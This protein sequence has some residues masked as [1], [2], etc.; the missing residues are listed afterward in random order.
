LLTSPRPF[1]SLARR[2]LVVAVT[3]AL[4][5][6]FGSGPALAAEIPTPSEFLGIPVGAD[7]TIAD[8]RQIRGYFDALDQAS[9]RVEVE[10]LGETTLGEE[11]FL[12][13]ISSEA[14]VA[15]KARL[16]QISRQIAD[17][18]GLSDPEVEALVAEG[19]LILL[20]T[21]NIHSTE[22]GASQMAMEWAHA[23]ASA[24][25]EETVRRLDE[26]MLLLVPS[27]NPDGQVM[28]TEWYRKNLDTDYEG[29]PMP[30]LYH[31]YA[32]HD[33]NRDWFMLTQKETKAV[34]RAVYH[35]WLPQVWL[36]E[37]QMGRDGPRMFLPPYT[38][39]V[40]PDIHPLV[41]REVNLIGAQMALRLEQAGKSGVIYGY[42][43]DAYW[44]G[45]TK[46]TAWWKNVSGLLTEVASVRYATPV[47]V[48]PNELS[49]G[50]KGLVEYGP[51]TSF[52]NPWPGG[53]WR[54]RDIMDYERIASDAILE[55][56]ADRREDFLRNA[57]VRARAAVAAFGERDAYR[58]PADQR[59][60]ATAARLAALMDEHG[61]EVRRAG[62]GDVYIPLAQ[63]Y[64]LFVREMLSVQRYPQVKLVSGQDIVRPYDVSAWTL[65]LMMGVEAERAEMPVGLVA[66]TPRAVD[67][68]VG[69][70]AFAIA[71]GRPEAARLVNAALRTNG[72]VRVARRALSDGV[73]GWPAGTVF[74]DAAAARAAAEK[75]VPAQSWVPVE[76]ILEAAEPLAAPR[77]G[78]YKP[79]QASMDE[80]W[81]RFV[82]E[83]YGFEPKTLDN[84]AVRQGDL[85]ASFDVIVLP[86]VPKETIETGKRRSRR[87]GA[88]RYAPQLP[89]EYR[90]GLEK[91]GAEALRGFVEG[92]GTLV[93]LAESSEY[94]MEAF[95]LPVRNAL[96]NGGEDFACPGALLRAEVTPDHP[97]TWGL[98]GELAVFQ[99]DE[100]AFDT[101]LPGAEM[102]RW[103]LATFPK[104]SEDVLLSGWMRGQEKIARRAAAV[105]T[106]W[107]RGRIVLFGFRVQER[108]QTA[109]TFPFLFNALYWST[110]PPTRP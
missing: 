47:R 30:W 95:D 55:T 68:P 16:Q 32:G 76:A 98:P 29:G 104:D 35:E 101:T 24:E 44:P 64:G 1:F 105:A 17:P 23:L 88:M 6:A 31:H 109:A 2:R 46:N 25:D 61:V 58:I 43:Y 80:G 27:V 34:S 28:E 79:W 99:T 9:P 92:G 53:W 26:V 102:D 37:H 54:L 94:V 4:A 66:W 39:P 78:L 108:A 84:K 73:Q 91:E 45:G 13:V 48:E 3:V 36:D 49:G 103:V 67:L 93:A 62:N 65:P 22:V 82:L 77:V 87:P 81:T 19:R 18:R 107:G 59:D 57:V 110:A 12:A 63:P 106:T 5:A 60:P 20:I 72:R 7:R 8:Y 86:S 10:V 83:T 70:E 96:G 38:E 50:R 11:L 100:L 71:P 89:E 33:N 90:G 85:G 52:P 14:N 21:C 69:G 74:I 42:A 97:V 51:Q 40:D 75:G 56:C 15:N 41:W